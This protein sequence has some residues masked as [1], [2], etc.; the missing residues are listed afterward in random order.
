M[1]SKIIRNRV[2]GFT[3]VELLIV[4]VVIGILAAIVTVAYT[5]ISGRANDAAVQSDLVGMAKKLEIERVSTGRY[6]LPPTTGTDIH[7]TKGAYRDQ[8]NLYY[9]YDSANDRYAVQA[10]SVSNNYFKIVDGVVSSG[11]GPA[12]YSGE[13]TCDIMDPAIVWGGGTASLGYTV[14]G[15]WATWAQ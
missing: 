8:N 5:G 12:G 4:V 7:I 14:G 9:C 13:G 10:R 1:E 11:A 3:I 15:T 6:P 2:T